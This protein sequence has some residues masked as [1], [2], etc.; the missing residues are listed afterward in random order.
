MKS[1]SATHRGR[2]MRGRKSAPGTAFSPCGGWFTSRSSTTC[3]SA[4]NRECRIQAGPPRA[5]SRADDKMIDVMDLSRLEMRTVCSL[6][7]SHGTMTNPAPRTGTRNLEQR[8]IQITHHKSQST[9][10]VQEQGAAAQI[11][12]TPGGGKDLGRDLRGVESR[13]RGPEAS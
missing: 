1:R 5:E 11:R 9:H 8:R 6:R 4:T 3:T 12:A 13:N 2:G 7:P 10:A